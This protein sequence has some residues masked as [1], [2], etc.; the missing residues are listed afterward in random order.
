MKDCDKWNSYISNKLHMIYI[1]SN[2]DGHPLIK[3]FNTV[4]DT[5]VLPI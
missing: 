2:N 4:A 1:S 3:T 5:P